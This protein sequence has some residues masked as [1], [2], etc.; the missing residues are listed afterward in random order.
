MNRLTTLPSA[1][2]AALALTLLASPSAAQSA[3]LTWQG[4]ILGSTV[5]YDMTGPFGQIYALVPSLNAGPTPLAIFDPLDPRSLDVGLDLF[6]LA[7]FGALLP[8]ASVT[9]PLI[10]GFSGFELHA[11]F[12][13]IDPLGGTATLVDQI[14]NTAVFIMGQS[15]DMLGTR[16][17]LVTARQGHSTTL[18]DDG[19]VLIVG[20][21]EP[22][23]AGNLNTTND[24]ELYDPQTQT[25][26]PGG[27]L[28]QARS[29]QTATKLLDGRVLIVGGYPINGPSIASATAE[30][31]DPATGT[32]TA[33]AA[34][35]MGRTLHTATLLNDG[36]VF[37]VGGAAKF[38][39]ND[40]FGS[41]A[42]VVK[43]TELYDPATNSWTP[44][45]NL[46]SPLF[47]HQATLLGD[48]KVLISSGVEVASLFG[49]PIPGIT[50]SC[51]RFNPVTNS[52]VSTA[53]MPQGRAYHGQIALPGGGAM[54][55]GG[56][57][58]DFTALVF[59]THT[60]VFTYN[61]LTNAWTTAGQLNV[62]RAYPN[63]VDVG[64]SIKVIAGLKTVDITTGSGTPATE[65]EGSSYSGLTWTTE[66]NQA[67]AREVAR[68]VAIDAGLRVLIVGV[69]DNGL[70]AVD[71]TAE[72]F[73]P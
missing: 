16:G 36:R 73:I 12:A 21:D 54:A 39:L 19:R 22:D 58:G 57:T 52:F 46:P 38:D 44:G 29:T 53:S 31:F 42:T 56:A 28:T 32:S 72:V 35:A 18:L 10:P 71:K 47:A 40:V 33:V 68:A 15:G 48:G 37:V 67:L 20:G 64:G 17:D 43:T 59:V 69:G 55:V 63:L 5:Q 26:V 14:S 8:T 49:I 70:A 23:G 41:L 11:Q 24:F 51:H 65:V 7:K 1:A 3:E 6:S 66:A 60:D 34:P 9:L 61:H 45:P 2:A 13:T 25:F 30:I 4:G 50:S 62:G 27:P